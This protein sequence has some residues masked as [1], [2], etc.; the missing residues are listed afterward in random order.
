MTKPACPELVKNKIICIRNPA[1][2]L[3][4]ADDVPLSVKNVSRSQLFPWPF[5]LGAE[6]RPNMKTGNCFPV[7]RKISPVGSLHIFASSKNKVCG[8]SY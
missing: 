4:Y 3:I 5:V 2:L 6:S 1:G 7:E 8:I